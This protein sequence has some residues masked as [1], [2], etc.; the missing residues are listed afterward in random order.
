MSEYRM[1]EAAELLGVGVDTVR[2]WADQGRLSTTRTDG[3]HRVVDGA[4]LARLAV[5]LA[6][7]PDSDTHMSARNRFEGL[8]TEVI[9][10][11]VMA[12]VELQCGRNRIV[13]LI[14]SEAVRDLELRPGVRAV[15]TVKATNVLIETP[16]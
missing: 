14:S 4:E 1:G 15:A 6:D 11:R 13:A 7:H 5:E 10:D 2:R 12:Q 16:G 8:V 3:N 9:A